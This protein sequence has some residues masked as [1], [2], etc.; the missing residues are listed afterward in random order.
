M[1]RVELLIERAVA[2]KL[3]GSGMI[4]VNPPF[5]LEDELR[6]ILPALVKA[7]GRDGAS[8]RI[9]WIEGSSRATAL[10]A[11]LSPAGRGD[12]TETSAHRPSPRGERCLAKQGG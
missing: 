7:L 3:Y 9:E 8:H 2:G 5:V 12:S 6:T 10:G 1:L 4:V 11:A